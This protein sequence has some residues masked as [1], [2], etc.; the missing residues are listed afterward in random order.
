MDD[1]VIRAARRAVLDPHFLAFGLGRY[2]EERQMD[3][4]GLMAALGATPE[5]LAHARLCRTPRTDPAGLREDVGRI[6]DK[7]GL[8]AAVLAEAVQAGRV[9][10]VHRA[11]AER[12]L[13]EAAAPLLAA[14]DRAEGGRR[15]AD[16]GTEDDQPGT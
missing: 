10:E 4:R 1:L 6:A 9:A 11:S 14:R 16:G 12:E 15:T 3:E 7:F 5:T 8:N 13:P 2:A